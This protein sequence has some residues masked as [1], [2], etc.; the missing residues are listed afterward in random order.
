[1]PYVDN[2]ERLLRKFET[3][4]DLL[5]R[6]VLKPATKPTRVGVIHY[7]ST[8]PAMD[9][10]QALLA[11]DGLHIDTL[12]IRAFPLALEVAEF[13]REHEHVFIVEQNRDTQIRT[14]RT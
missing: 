1:G 4:R 3:A 9:E 7:G 13:V 12:R 11:S 6:P 10:A 14:L 5:P 2:M 8:A